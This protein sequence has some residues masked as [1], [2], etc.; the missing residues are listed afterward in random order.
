MQPAGTG[1]LQLVERSRPII[2]QQPRQRAVG[3]DAASGLAARAVVGLV[4]GVADPLYGGAADRARFAEPAVDGHARAERRDF[5]GKAVAGLGAESLDP[6]EENLTRGGIEPLDLARAP[7]SARG[8][9]A[10]AGAMEDL[11][12]IGV[13][14]A[15]E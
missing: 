13:A 2:F 15:A 14:D 8:P 12:G 7:A 6:F 5:L 9:A 4:V 10:R 3:E 1:A 11:V